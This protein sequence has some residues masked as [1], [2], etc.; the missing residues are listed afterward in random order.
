MRT[1]TEPGAI[2]LM[3]TV[4]SLPGQQGEER[5]DLELTRLEQYVLLHEVGSGGMGVVYAA[6]DETLDR[7]VA[8]KLLH[9]EEGAQPRLHREA[10]AMARLSHPNVVPVFETG[11]TE[12]RA[13]I[14]MEFVD[15]QTLGRWLR[16]ATRSRAAILAVFRGAAEG[17]IAAHEQGLVHR[18]FKPDNVMV[19]G[20]GRA[21]VMDFGVARA[22]ASGGCGG[23]SVALDALIES[24][25]L[26]NQLTCNSDIT[27]LTKTGTILGTPA[28][29]APE[30]F[31]GNGSEDALADQFSFCVALWEALFGCRPF[32]GDSLLT[33]EQ[34]ILDRAYSTPSAH[35]VP[36]WLRRVLERGLAPTPDERWPSMRALLDALDD[37]PTRRR[38]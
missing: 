31:R 13:Y 1:P 23:S 28:Y 12:G 11:Q 8:I 15:G 30:Q 14:V 9:E 16:A 34:A 29:M 2:D 7:K 32:A 38:R 6:Y 36:T 18:D 33:L 27:A 4:Q 25:E 26:S 37:D 22:G 20:D 3:A 35:D 24:G 5:A 19:R 10:Q 17:L 21:M